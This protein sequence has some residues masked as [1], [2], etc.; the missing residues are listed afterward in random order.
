MPNSTNNIDIGTNP[1]STAVSAS[2]FESTGAILVNGEWC[3]RLP[4]ECVKTFTNHNLL[5]TFCVEQKGNYYLRY[6]GLSNID[7]LTIL[8]RTAVAPDHF[9]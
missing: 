9:T 7:V 6:E 3:F 8:S 5:I 2:P 4:K 1:N